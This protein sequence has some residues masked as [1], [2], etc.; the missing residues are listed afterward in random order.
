MKQ[1]E[2]VKLSNIQRQVVMDLQNG[3]CLCTDSSSPNVWVGLPNGSQYM[4]K[5]RVF[6]NLY[7]KQMI[8]QSLKWPF[9]YILTAQGESYGK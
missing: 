5:G 2:N 8:Y 1:S 6:W 7:N 9:Y 3:G 4:I